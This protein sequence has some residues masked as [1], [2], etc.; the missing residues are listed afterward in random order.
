MELYMLSC[1]FNL[2]R[3]YNLLAR[4]KR[5]YSVTVMLKRMK[6]K[7]GVTECQGSSKRKRKKD[8]I[9]NGKELMGEVTFDINIDKEIGFQCM[10][11]EEE[12]LPN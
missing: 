3:V 9:K 4:K 11:V 12:E 2:E 8:Y 6:Y 5:K 10:K 7:E 1:N